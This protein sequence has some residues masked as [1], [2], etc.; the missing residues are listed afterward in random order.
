MAK[1][2]IDTCYCVYLLEAPEE[3]VLHI[4]EYIQKYILNG[5][6]HQY[7]NKNTQDMTYEVEGFVEFLN[8]EY[9]QSSEEKVRILEKDVENIRNIGENG[10][11]KYPMVFLD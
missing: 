10:F 1:I 8:N 3:I 11:Y 2:A 9:L 6:G 5:E 4:S 7:F